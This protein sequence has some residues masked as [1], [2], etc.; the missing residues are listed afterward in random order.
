MAEQQ[1]KAKITTCPETVGKEPNE[2]PNPAIERIGR[3]YECAADFPTTL[4]EAV[5]EWGKELCFN[6]MMGAVVIDCQSAMRSFIKSEDF[7]E[8]GLQKLVS[9]FNPSLKKAGVS[10]NEKVEDHLA[11]LDEGAIAALLERVRAREAEEDE[12][13]A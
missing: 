13:A 3:V 5:S 11:S 12:A 8:A 2:R 9:G 4:D 6:R 1:I 10:F 7:S